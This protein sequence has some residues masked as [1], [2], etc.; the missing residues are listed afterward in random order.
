MANCVDPD[1]TA[2]W[3]AVWSGSA[4]FAYVILSETLMF[5]FL[6]HLPCVLCPDYVDVQAKACVL[7]LNLV[8]SLC[9]WWVQQYLLSCR[10]RKTIN[11]FLLLL[12][13]KALCT[14][15]VPFSGLIQQM[16]N[17]WYFFFFFFFPRKQDLPF[18]ANCL[19]WRQFAWKVKSC[20]ETI[21]MKWQILF[22][23]ISWFAWNV[24]SHFLGEKKSKWSS[25]ENFTQSF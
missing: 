5:E 1:Q 24:K 7:R 6:G 13:K 19:H 11:T 14:R 23:G 15:V 9:F 18:H 20:L 10:K 16:T 17:W 12:L 21:C 4:L 25:A 3:G 22:S 8:N 2:P